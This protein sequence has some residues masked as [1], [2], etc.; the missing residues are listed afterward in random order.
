MKKTVLFMLLLV[1]TLAF[2]QKTI[3]L[4]FYDGF[5]YGAPGD[6]MFPSSDPTVDGF[7]K[8]TYTGTYS[9]NTSANPTIEGQPVWRTDTGLPAFTGN[10]IKFQGGTEDPQLL[11]AN[12]ESTGIIYASFIFKI[13][14]LGDQDANYN[15][16]TQYFFAFARQGT[17]SLNYASTVYIRKDITSGTLGEFNIGVGETNNTGIVVWDTQ[18][19][20]FDDEIVI[21]IAYDFNTFNS[22]LWINPS[23]A[24]G[25]ANNPTITTTETA[26]GNRTTLD[27]VRIN[28]NNTAE[29][30]TTIL[31]ELRVGKTWASV[32]P[33]AIL[34]VSKNNIEGLKIYPNPAK[35]YITIES[36]NVKLSSV[37]L[38]NVLGSRILSQKT[39]T[40]NRLNVAG[41]SKGIYMLKVNAE[42]ASTT[43]KIVID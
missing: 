12:E 7:G 32:F 43:K 1:T 39:L 33:N 5:N 13:N 38:Y 27:R 21:V 11:F 29:T 3:T 28:K 17:S 34:S 16:T 6:R 19:F 30:A 41:I 14:A 22:S 35:D 23:I 36:K 24:A 37:E 10:A 31:D 8:W 18:K 26:T 20:S 25:T 15:G 42:G 2:G 40:N 4:P 9:T